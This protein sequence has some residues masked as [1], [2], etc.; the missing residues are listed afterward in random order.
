MNRQQ[1]DRLNEEYMTAKAASFSD[2]NNAKTLAS[3]ISL[4]EKRLDA[5]DETLGQ[6]SEQDLASDYVQAVD[7]L[8]SFFDDIILECA[9]ITGRRAK[10]EDKILNLCN[11]AVAK[12]TN[13]DEANEHV[14]AKLTDCLAE[15]PGPKVSA[16]MAAYLLDETNPLRLGLSSYESFCAKNPEIQDPQALEYLKTEAEV[17]REMIK[18]NDNQVLDGLDKM[19]ASPINCAEKFLLLSLNSFYHGLVD[20]A[21]TTIEIGLKS[22]PN[23][24]RLLSAKSALSA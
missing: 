11:I 1:H 18:G 23:S 19:L 16:Q 9:E 17:R 6:I 24:E 21:K 5:M 13:R 2:E 3:I 15:P 22:F 14:V 4:A 10:T 7:T 20:D 8:V 12:A